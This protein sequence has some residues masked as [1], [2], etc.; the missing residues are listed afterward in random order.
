VAQR[1]ILVATEREHRLVHLLGIEHLQAHE[2]VEVLYRQ[3]SDG[4]EERE[5]SRQQTSL[6]PQRGPRLSNLSFERFRSSAKYRDR[7][8]LQTS[9]SVSPRTGFKA[10]LWRLAPTNQSGSFRRRVG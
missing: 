10:E 1:G 7:P 6:S 8:P 9:A 4:Y 5:A 2:Q 3:T